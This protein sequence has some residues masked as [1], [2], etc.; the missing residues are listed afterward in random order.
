MGE[1][2]VL[3]LTRRRQAKDWNPEPRRP[4]CRPEPL[5]KPVA[6]FGLFSPS[7]TK[8]ACSPPGRRLLPAGAGRCDDLPAM[9]TSTKSGDSITRS[10]R[11]S[12][13]SLLPSEF[14]GRSV[15]QRGRRR[16]GGRI[17]QHGRREDLHLGEILPIGSLV[18]RRR[19][20]ECQIVTVMIPRRHRRSNLPAG[21]ALDKRRPEVALAHRERSQQ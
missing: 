9:A 21:S 3:L 8:P 18:S 16:S 1:P 5:S 7:F 14:G 19:G 2:V 10:T 4:G 13:L 20:G 17:V 11:R 6:G 15:C 12:S